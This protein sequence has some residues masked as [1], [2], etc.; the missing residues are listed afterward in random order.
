MLVD[1]PMEVDNSTGGSTE[2][3]LFDE[4]QVYLMPTFCYDIPDYFQST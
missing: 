2:D 3:V 1:D 4:K